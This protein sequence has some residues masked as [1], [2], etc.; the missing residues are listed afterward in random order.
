MVFL[1]YAVKASSQSHMNLQKMY[2]SLL[3][4]TMLIYYLSTF[5]LYKKKKAKK[6]KWLHRLLM[7]GLLT[8]TLMPWFFHLFRAVCVQ[9]IH[10]GVGYFVRN[11]GQCS[12][13]ATDHLRLGKAAPSNP[14][15]GVL[16]AQDNSQTLHLADYAELYPKVTQKDSK[17]EQTDA[18]ISLSEQAQGYT[19]SFFAVKTGGPG[20]T[21]RLQQSVL[22]ALFLA[23]YLFLLVATVSSTF[24]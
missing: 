13:L 24:L 14:F 9:G 12:V 23:A 18:A 21:S 1:L 5:S 20:A 19:N 11:G 3:A 10:T 8:L 4:V 22:D 2:P 7:L 17:P 15:V 6:S 16:P